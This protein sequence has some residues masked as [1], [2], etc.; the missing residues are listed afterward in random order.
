MP[1]HPTLRQHRVRPGRQVPSAKI[2]L[3]SLSQTKSRICPPAVWRSGLHSFG[4]GGEEDSPP[5]CFSPGLPSPGYDDLANLAGRLA[6]ILPQ[7]GSP[8][9]GGHWRRYG[10][11]PGPTL[12]RLP[13]PLLCLDGLELPDG[14]FLDVAAPVAGE[15]IPW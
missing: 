7:L 11:G 2:C 10:Q 8:R 15:P 13:G 14:S 5:P 12:T 4:P 9:C 6:E 1:Q 3:S